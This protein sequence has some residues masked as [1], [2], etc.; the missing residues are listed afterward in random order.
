MLRSNIIG[1][2]DLEEFGALFKEEFPIPYVSGVV[3][4]KVPINKSKK[5]V[6]ELVRRPASETKA[7][8]SWFSRSYASLAAFLRSMRTKGWNLLIVVSD[9]SHPLTLLGIPLLLCL[10][11]VWSLMQIDD[12]NQDIYAPTFDIDSVFNSSSYKFWIDNLSG[13]WVFFSLG[14][15]SLV[16]ILS[17]LCELV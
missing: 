5:Y 3:C 4:K 9:L 12:I 14:I 7:G 13:V 17:G 16:F 1:S 2:P 11:L 15:L 6:S 8:T 10:A